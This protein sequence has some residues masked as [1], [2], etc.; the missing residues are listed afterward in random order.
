MVKEDPIVCCL[1]D[2]DKKEKIAIFTHANPDPD[3]IGSAIG[4]QW[5]LKKKLTIQSEIFYAGEISHSQ[6]KTMVNVLSL[7]GKLKKAEE[8]AEDNFGKIILV[9]GTEQNSGVKGLEA[10]IVIDHHRSKVDPKDYD[11]V[12]IREI[13]SCCA[14]IYDHME[15]DGLE[16]STADEDKIVATAMLLGIKTDTNDLLTENTAD[17]DNRAYQAL[18]KIADVSKIS[19]IMN[20][21]LPKYFFEL[22]SE[23]FK[24]ENSTQINAAW[25]SFVGIISATKRDSLPMLADKFV[26]MEGI[27]TSII[28]AIVEDEIHASIR[29]DDVSLDVDAFCRKIFGKN[30][31]GGKYGAGGARI[32]LEF[33]G[34]TDQDP[35]VKESIAKAVQSIITKKIEKEVKGN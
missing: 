22:E 35:E 4:V 16:F 24:E 18:A 10:D 33:F 21:P 6:N 12:D 3:A 32:P 9:D 25:V 2:F 20:Y 34:V 29:S 1:Q 31:A 27:S 26:R 5:F 19:D 13:G 23:A 14:L 30:H 8:Y 28:F 15:K 17:L 7:S 11:F